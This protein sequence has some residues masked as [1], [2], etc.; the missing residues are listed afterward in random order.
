MIAPT[1]T[2][3]TR[4]A[5]LHP[6]RPPGEGG[7]DRHHMSPLLEVASPARGGGR[8]AGRHGRTDLGAARADS[9]QFLVTDHPIP[10]RRQLFEEKPVMRSPAGFRGVEIGLPML[11]SAFA[12]GLWV[13]AI[14]PAAAD[15]PRPAPAGKSRPNCVIPA[16]PAAPPASPGLRAF[17][18]PQTGELTRP[19]VGRRPD[20][21]PAPRAELST[22]GEGLVEVPVPAPSPGVMVH[23]QGR[24]RSDLTATVG[25]DGKVRVRHETPCADGADSKR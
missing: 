19:P 21:V 8:G 3:T 16:Q 4:V 10:L 11:L 12:L 13:F 25:P 17:V 22:S 20:G 23:L 1:M 15:E 9:N 14:Q 24:F 2:K 18:D 7:S 6:A 5:P